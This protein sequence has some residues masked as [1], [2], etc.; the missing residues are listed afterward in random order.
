MDVFDLAA[1]IIEKRD[2]LESAMGLIRRKEEIVLAAYHAGFS[3]ME[4]HRMTGMARTTID[5]IISGR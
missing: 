1:G 4:L 2:G 5:R 3:K